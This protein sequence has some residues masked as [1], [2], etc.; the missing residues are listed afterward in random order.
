MDR[1][2]FLTVGVGGASGFLA[3]AGDTEASMLKLP[4]GRPRPIPLPDMDAY[5][6]GIDAGMESISRWSPC[7]TCPSYSGDPEAIDNLARK[8][9]RTLYM[10]AMFSDLPIEGQQH[11][12]I[13]RR[14]FDAMP[15]MDEATSGM[16]AFLATR[17]PGNL[18]DLQLALRNPANPAMEI[19]EA[20][21]RQAAELGV[22]TPRRL[23]TRVMMTDASWR[24]R[25]QP[26]SL[27]ISETLEKIE[28]VVAADASDEART[29]WIAARVGE[30]IFWQRQQAGVAKLISA[31]E[32]V[33]DVAGGS[34]EGAKP[35]RSTREKRLAKGAR[36]MG[37]G[38]LVGVLAVAGAAVTS[39]HGI[40]WAFVF[41]ATVGAVMILVGL[42]VLLVG[43]LT[44]GDRKSSQ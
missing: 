28:K 4:E 30:Q 43:L 8:S 24:L 5:V 11:P 21:D 13:Q 36:L 39:E 9:L 31:D 41:G 14:I 17:S 44:P 1:R 42:L 34:S 40:A 33:D 7:S 2:D 6:A 29:D 18:D 23:Q 26:P 25:N 37:L 16:T 20:L 32:A 15:E 12:E 35:D 3:F 10:T 19:F 38:L 27:V 22:S